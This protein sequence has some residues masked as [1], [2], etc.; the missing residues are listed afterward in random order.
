MQ[1]FIIIFYLFVGEE[2]SGHR[3]TANKIREKKIEQSWLSV[4][5]INWHAERHGERKQLNSV[6]GIYH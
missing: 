6:D 1:N 3:Q 5:K 2:P 4:S